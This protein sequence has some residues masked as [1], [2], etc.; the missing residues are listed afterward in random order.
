MT[1][2]RTTILGVYLLAA[3]LLQLYFYLVMSM[4]TDEEAWLFYFDPR[5]GIFFLESIIREK[6]QVAPSVFR[7]FS[8]ALISSIGAVLVIGRPIV[9]TYIVSELILMIPNVIFFLF[10][11][12][13]NLSPAHGFSVSE[14]LFP[15]LV[16]MVFS[17][18]PLRLSFWCR[19]KT[20][21]QI[22]SLHLSR[23]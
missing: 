7:W 21:P 12:W 13:A 22:E 2:K 15:T 5:I 9:K 16:M 10:V 8:A 4:S 3:G 6:E 18:I 11:I 20:D 19:R 23:A 1:V 17:M 14:L